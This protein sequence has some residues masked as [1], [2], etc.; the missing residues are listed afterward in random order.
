MGFTG[1]MKHSFRRPSEPGT[2]VFTFVAVTMS[3]PADGIAISRI[4]DKTY[5]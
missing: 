2:N 1:R 4:D 5:R 3:V